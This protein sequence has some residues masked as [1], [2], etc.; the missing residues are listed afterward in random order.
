MNQ[1]LHHKVDHWETTYPWIK[2]PN[3]L[4]DNF[5]AA[6]AMLKST[7]NRLRK[8]PKLEETYEEQIQDLIDRKV[9]RMLT[10]EEMKEY[11]G[12]VHY[13]GHHEVMM[14]ILNRHHAE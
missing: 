3:L 12:P 1:N 10:D 5:L 14:K 6:R 9:A 13:L 8:S 7:Q 11:I 2:D 4:E